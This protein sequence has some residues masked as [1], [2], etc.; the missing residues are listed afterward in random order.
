MAPDQGAGV[1]LVAQEPVHGRLEPGLAGGRGD[2]VVVERAGDVEH[3]LAGRGHLEDAPHD[4]VHGRVEHERGALLAAVLDLDSLVAVGRTAGHP[5]PPRCSLAHPAR[6]LLGQVLRVELVD[7]LDDR[8]HQ[9]AGRGVVGVL[10]DRGDADPAPAQHRL[11]GDRV[12]ALAGEAGELP[13]QD[14]L[15]GRVVPGGFVQ[16]L[17]ELG[18]VG[19]AA[20]L[21]LVDVFPGDH[22]AIALGIVPE[23]PQLGGDGEVDILAIRGDA[24]V[25]RSCDEIHRLVH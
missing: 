22:V 21:G 7:R 4:L 14:L 3:A 20:R 5:E 8:L 10:G 19:D 25:E 13:D 9:L 2:A 18:P 15:E 17:R 24:G 12:F 16:H 6:D 11:E 1:G 23:R